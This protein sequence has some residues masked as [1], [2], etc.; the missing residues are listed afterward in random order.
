MCRNQPLTLEF[1]GG[2]ASMLRGIDC[3]CL[4]EAYQES[5]ANS[6]AAEGGASKRVGEFSH[7]CIGRA[8]RL[9]HEQDPCKEVPSWVMESVRAEDATPT[10][11]CSHHFGKEQTIQELF[12]FHHKCISHWCEGE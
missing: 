9:A 11:V 12:S 2:R 4:A 1:P 8:A 5:T 3:F 10:A 6:E 7:V